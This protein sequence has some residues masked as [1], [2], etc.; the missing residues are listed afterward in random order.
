MKRIFQNHLFQFATPWILKMQFKG[1]KVFHKSKTQP[2]TKLQ[3]IKDRK[4]DFY[5]QS[6]LFETIFL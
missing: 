5:Y 3:A 6:G 2:S 4:F 1:L